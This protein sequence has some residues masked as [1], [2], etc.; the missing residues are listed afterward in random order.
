MKSPTLIAL[1]V[2]AVVS[3]GTAMALPQAADDARPARKTLDANGDGFVDRAEAAAS[4]RLAA[5]FDSLDANR[6]GRLD[7]DEL[8]RHE[9][10]GRH[11]GKDRH[12][13]LQALDTDKDGRISRAEAAADPAFAQRFDRMDLNK[14]GFVD[15]ADRELAAAQRRDAWFKAAD[16]DGDGTLSRAEYDAASEQRDARHGGRQQ[17]PRAQ[18]G[19]WFA[20]LDKDKDGRIS[21]AEAAGSPLAGRFDA[22]DADKDGFIDR[23]ELKAARPQRR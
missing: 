16:T 6:D 3:A 14:D 22:L 4:P 5:R 13:Q 10:G 9:R 23:E 18:R 11:G 20:G 15:R 8:P 21:R 7:K 1:A 17:G 12:A 2:L 19:E